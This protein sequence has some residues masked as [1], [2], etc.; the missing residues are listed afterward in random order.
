MGIIWKPTALTRPRDLYASYLEDPTALAD[1]FPSHPWEAGWHDSRLAHLAR[2]DFARPVLAS[3]L[4]AYNRSVGASSAALT[5]AEA[6]ADACSAAIIGGQQAGVLTGPLY[7]ISKIVTVLRLARRIAEAP[8]VKAIP[9]FWVAAEDHDRAEVDHVWLIDDRGALIRLQLEL[10]DSV[11]GQ[12]VGAIALGDSASRLL[13][14]MD[15][16]LPPAEHRTW[17]LGL[18]EATAAAAS[19]VADWHARILARLFAKWGLVLV[20]PTDP[21]FA[22]LAAPTFHQFL[23]RAEDLAGA[24]EQGTHAVRTLGFPP[25]LEPGPGHAHVFLTDAQGRRVPLFRVPGGFQVGRGGG[26]YLDRDTAL[27]L[28]STESARLTSSGVTRPLVQDA[29]LPVLAQ[30]VGPG[31]TAYY[32]QLTEAF[33]R[34]GSV[35]P[36]LWPRMSFTVVDG[37]IRR[38]LDRYQV[39]FAQGLPGIQRRLAAILRDREEPGFASALAEA[40]SALNRHHR[41]ILQAATRL[42][43]DLRSMARSSHRRM[44][45]ELDRLQLRAAKVNRERQATLIH[46]FQRLEDCLFPRGRL[47]ERVLNVVPWLSHYGPAFL[48]WLMEAPPDVD[49]YRHSLLLL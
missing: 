24:V 9:C 12:P 31:E 44:G 26:Q 19:S 14:A 25:Q 17:V 1:R 40:R 35:V 37:P 21:A 6:L 7:T 41:E 29:I 23:K 38:W 20:N 46:H 18:L 8:G 28:T 15:E 4:A 32:A 5:N 45:H 10:P 49:H 34:F 47:Q 39:D 36:P 22:R 11:Q 43:P 16:V 42:D 2:R 3:A 48:E 33:E 30:V 27:R 13:A